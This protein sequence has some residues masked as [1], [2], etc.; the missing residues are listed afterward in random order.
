M[1][2]TELSFEIRRRYKSLRP[3]EQKVADFLLRP[4]LAADALTIEALADGAGTS[5]PTVIRF[6]RAMGF[7]G[8]R[9]LKTA[10]LFE[11]AAQHPAQRAVPSFDVTPEDK[12]LDIPFKVISTNIRQL[13]N[14]LK[15]LSTYELIRAV[16]AIG[17]ARSVFLIAAENSCAVAE[18][19]ATKLLYLG[20]QTVFYQDAYRQTVGVRNLGAEDV[21]LAISYTGASGS[22]VEALRRAKQAGVPTVAITNFEQVPVNRYADIVLCTGNEDYLYKGTIFSRCAQLAVVDMLYTGLLVTDY[23]RYIENIEAGG[24][25]TRSFTCRTDGEGHV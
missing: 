18:D 8:F 10:L 3:S 6:A 11:Q 21:A 13:E 22:T 1:N 16:E 7:R 4:E 17:R 19:L 14:T 2:A 24:R 25:I 12:L 23:R 20:I 9:E 5:Q 15:T